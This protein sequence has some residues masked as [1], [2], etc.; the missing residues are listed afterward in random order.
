MGV[1]N[2]QPENKKVRKEKLVQKQELKNLVGLRNLGNTCFMS[3]V[4]QSLGNI[5]EFCRV[6]KQLPTLDLEELNKSSGSLSSS[7]SSSPLSNSSNGSDKSSRES[8]NKN[9]L[10][11]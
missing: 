2:N 6:L 8:R 4:L 3:A 11:A 9:G 10:P 1:E 5:H 7:S